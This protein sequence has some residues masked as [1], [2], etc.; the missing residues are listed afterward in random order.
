MARQPAYAS[1]VLFIMT[2]RLERRILPRMVYA[3]TIYAT[4]SLEIKYRSQVRFP[5]HGTSMLMLLKNY[6]ISSQ[7]SHLLA[8]SFS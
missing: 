5:L 2:L 3:A 1:A 6:L 7:G 8:L 4:Q